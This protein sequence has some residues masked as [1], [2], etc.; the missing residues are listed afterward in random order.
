MDPRYTAR[1]VTVDR[2]AQTLTIVWQDGHRSVFPLDGLRR[3]CPCAACRG[4]EGT[5]ELPDP[6]LFRVPALM[7]WEHLRL[8]PVGHYALRF[9]WDDGHDTGIYTWRRLRAMCPCDACTQT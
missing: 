1:R 5:D 4:H 3:A 7:R 2:E 8:E 9:I 6:A